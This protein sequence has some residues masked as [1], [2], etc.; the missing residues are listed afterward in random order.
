MRIYL[1]RK[2]GK[3][4]LYPKSNGRTIEGTE[5]GEDEVRWAAVSRV[6]QS[7]TDAT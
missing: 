2:S 4:G 6:A 1:V 5:I 3:N 7:R